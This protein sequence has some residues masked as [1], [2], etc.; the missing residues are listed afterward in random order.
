ML[1]VCL[2]TLF[3]EATRT[4]NGTVITCYNQLARTRIDQPLQRYLCRKESL[5]ERGDD[6]P[7]PIPNP[8]DSQPN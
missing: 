6:K 4:T 2:N 3:G 8:N 5:V 7:Q 1:I